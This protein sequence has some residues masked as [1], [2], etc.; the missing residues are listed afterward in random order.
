MATICKKIF[1]LRRQHGISQEELAD[2]INVTRQA[3][4][5]WETGSAV[6]NSENITALCKLFNVSADYFLDDSKEIAVGFAEGAESAEYAEH[7]NG[8]EQA[9]TTVETKV[10]PK[11]SGK[12]VWITLMT[13]FAV[14]CVASISVT[15]ILFAIIIFDGSGYETVYA[16]RAQ[17]WLLP[18]C[19]GCTVI[20]LAA[21]IITIFCKDKFFRCDS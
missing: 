16:V 21:M 17:E 9:E 3:V 6:P 19:V 12:R 18:V 4:S 20:F 5:K 2:K 10:M 13:V 8:E 15:S 7:R 14:L 1:R 11:S